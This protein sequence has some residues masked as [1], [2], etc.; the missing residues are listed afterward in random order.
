MADS[1]EKVDFVCSAL[2]IAD[3]VKNSGS[4]GTYDYIISSHNFEHLPDPIRFLRGCGEVLAPN[5]YLSMAIPD[6]RRTFDYVRAVSRTSD[7]LR[8]YFEKKTQPSAYD[9]YD[10]SKSLGNIPPLKATRVQNPLWINSLDEEFRALT[11]RSNNNANYEDCHVTVYTP[12]S[13]R[14]IMLELIRLDL[15]PFQI[16]EV[17]ATPN[18]E[19][20]VHMKNVGYSHIS[21]CDITDAVLLDAYISGF[22]GE[23]SILPPKTKNFKKLWKAIKRK[24]LPSTPV[25]T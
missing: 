22:A 3:A 21:R 7:L 24:M 1:I 14:A 2:D 5:G 20:Y 10:G 9:L 18:M 11:N 16:I 12:E 19:F 17:A 15:I 6:K 4:T 25:M 13:F 23:S 8:C